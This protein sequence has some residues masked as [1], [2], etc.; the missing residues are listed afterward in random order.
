MN[1]F[2]FIFFVCPLTCFTLRHV[3]PQVFPRVGGIFTHTDLPHPESQLQTDSNG[4]SHGS[5]NHHLHLVPNT[6]TSCAADN[7]PAI[8]APATMRPEKRT[9]T[10]DQHTSAT[11]VA[12]SWRY[13]PL[14]KG[15]TR[16]ST[17]H[18]SAGATRSTDSTGGKGDRL[19]SSSSRD[20]VPLRRDSSRY[21][22]SSSSVRS[23][24]LEAGPRMPDRNAHVVS[25]GHVPIPP[26][27]P[28]AFRHR[29]MRSRGQ[30]QQPPLR[31]TSRERRRASH[32]DPSAGWHLTTGRVAGTAELVAAAAPSPLDASLSSSPSADSTSTSNRV[33]AAADAAATG[34]ASVSLPPSVLAASPA[35]PA[36][37]P[38]KHNSSTCLVPQ[39]E[40]AGADMVGV[41]SSPANEPAEEVMDYAADTSSSTYDPPAS[42]RDQRTPSFATTASLLSS[43][44]STSDEGVSVSET[45]SPPVVT[46]AGDVRKCSSRAP[47]SIDVGP[48]AT[49]SGGRSNRVRKRPRRLKTQGKV[50]NGAAGARNAFRSMW[51][52]AATH[53]PFV[54][55]M[56]SSCFTPQCVSGKSTKS[57]TACG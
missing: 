3:H 14:P 40:D 53:L 51:R 45:S 4:G 37:P 33:A 16:S 39:E 43:V 41:S 57:G 21:H 20:A 24:R 2:L 27:P 32:P 31:G 29:R 30:L 19:S 18:R 47:P 34:T 54:G 49:S 42:N 6:A 17:R 7:A 46:S 15:I 1:I 26:P 50:P 28:A 9:A 38:S 25:P 5:S 48:C 44:L 11:P 56:L 52:R 22:S 12:M 8:T 10:P 13:H 23:T 55:V 36:L 35:V